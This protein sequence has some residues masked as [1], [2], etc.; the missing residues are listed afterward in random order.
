MR[1]VL[2]QLFLNNAIKVDDVDILAFVIR[3]GYSHK[4]VLDFPD[5]VHRR[6]M[7]EDS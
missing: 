4:L 6:A 7:G 3:K 5:Q 1:K 2:S